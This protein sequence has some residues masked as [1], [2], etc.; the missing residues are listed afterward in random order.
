MA[1]GEEKSHPTIVKRISLGQEGLA[2]TLFTGE[3]QITVVP[4]AR[5]LSIDDMAILPAI[6]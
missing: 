1:G 6:D 2:K 3:R 4:A 5:M